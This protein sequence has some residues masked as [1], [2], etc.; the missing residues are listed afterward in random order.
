M[1]VYSYLMENLDPDKVAVLSQ[2]EEVNYSDLQNMIGQIYTCLQNHNVGHGECIAILGHNSSFWV[3]CYLAI[4]RYGAVAVPIPTDQHPTMIHEFLEMVD[5]QLCFMD[6]AHQKKF[7]D[8]S[9]EHIVTPQDLRQIDSII[10]QPVYNPKPNDLAA[11]MFTSGSTGIPNAVKVSHQNIIANT[12]SIIEYL[13]LTEEDRMMVVLPFYYC[14][15]TSLLHTHLR[16]G[17]SIVLNNQFMFVEK[18]LDDIENFSCTGF[19][20]VPSIYQ[21]LVKRS[22]FLNRTLVLIKHFQQAGGRLSHIFIEPIVKAFPE[23]DFFVMYGQTEATSRLAYLPPSLVLKKA[24]SIGQAI[25][26]TKLEIVDE[27]G[28]SIQQGESGELVA[29]G[30]NVTS[31]YWNEQPN[32]RFKDGKLYTGDLATIDEEG[33]IYLVGRKSDFLKP[34]GNRFSTQKIVDVL[35][36]HPMIVEAEVIGSYDDDLGEVIHAFIGVGDYEVT[37]NDIKR[38]CLEQL[39]R[40]AIPQNITIQSELPKSSAGKV[41]RRLLLDY[42]ADTINS[43]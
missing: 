26:Y 9:V 6:D 11:L 8:L 21:R 32:S 41:Q 39:P 37:E 7:S 36:Q 16:I 18:V 14:F 28:K 1:N 40:F 5:C 27:D 23:K 24:G 31:G 42:N 15:G 12:K 38:H 17:G 29:S 34:G 2:T 43:N 19:A 22:T 25:P 4:L 20:G 35:V 30:E 13:K 10:D 33:Y 3:A